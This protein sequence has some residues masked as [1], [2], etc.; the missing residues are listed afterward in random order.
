[1]TYL[2]D[3]DYVADWLQGTAR[4]A[5]IRDALGSEQLAISIITYGEIYE[6]IYYGRD[7]HA[8]EKVFLQFLRS[9][10]VLPLTRRIM[11]RF[12]RIR[13]DLRARGQLIGDPDILIAA[14]AL[15]HGL[16]LV[17]RNVT[18]FRRIPGLKLCEQR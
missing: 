4:A 13:G 5:Q 11:R 16:T 1:M 9:V 2:I 3:S 6:G 7:P 18:H 14:T 8:A 10:D 15:H 12:A 17:T